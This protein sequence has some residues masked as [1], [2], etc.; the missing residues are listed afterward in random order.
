MNG[1]RNTAGHQSDG[2]KMSRLHSPSGFE[3]LQQPFQSAMLL[4]EE[5]SYATDSL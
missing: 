3:L 4:N 5:I 1:G 2:F